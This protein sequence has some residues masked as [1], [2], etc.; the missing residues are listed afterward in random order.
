MKEVRYWYRRILIMIL[1]FSVSVGGGY[2]LIE[3]KKQM[4]QQE[5]NAEPV[6]QEMVIPGGMP[7]GIYLE[8]KGVMVL[9]TDAITG[10]D[11]MQ[12]EPAA[13]RVKAGDYIVA[14][15]HQTIE[16]K[17]ELQEAVNDLDSKEVV[18]TVQ[19]NQEK[20]DVR[21]E[22]VKTKKEDY[23]LGIWVRDNAQ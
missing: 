16:N 20:I 2:Y 6:E 22:A 1:V 8:T 12:Y 18:L 19:R 10:E 13:K 9:G 23:M 17:K 5:V 15:N 21:T 3:S 4:F 14:L 7:V 11:G